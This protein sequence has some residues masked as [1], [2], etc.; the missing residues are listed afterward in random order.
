MHI[1]AQVFNYDAF[2]QL[3]DN[4]FN[5]PYSHI[6][7]SECGFNGNV[8]SYRVYRLHERWLALNTRLQSDLLPRLASR[9]ATASP[10]ITVTRRTDVVTE[11]RL[12]ET[13]QAF[14]NIQSCLEWIENKQVRKER[15]KERKKERRKEWINELMN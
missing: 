9:S 8:L 6:G 1:F 2:C 3:D 4:E 12:T 7:Y 11:T 10:S 13:N 15:K 5:L 14:R